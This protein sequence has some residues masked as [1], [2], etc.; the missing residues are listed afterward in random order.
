MMYGWYGDGGIWG[1][2]AMGI[3]ML[4]F[5]GG[6]ITVVVLLIRGSR[7]GWGGGGYYHPG[8]QHDDPERILSQRFARG[9][10]DETE[11]KARLDALR[12]RP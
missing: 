1:W 2:V 6:V 4:L 12:R 7:A 9:E 11:Y 3:M 10:I 8:S 5:W